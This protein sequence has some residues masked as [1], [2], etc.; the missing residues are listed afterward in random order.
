MAPT[1]TL[2]WRF[3]AVRVRLTFFR[4][5]G[6]C[7]GRFGWL[8]TLRLY[9]TGRFFTESGS[10]RSSCSRALDL[11]GAGGLDGTKP[12]SRRVAVPVVSAWPYCDR[13][14][15]VF[16]ARFEAKLSSNGL[17]LVLDQSGSGITL[18]EPMVGGPVSSFAA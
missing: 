3:H 4:C 6:L 7:Q 13:E 17:E 8:A 18:A 15:C 16:L 9:K 14:R 11:P 2:D 5:L 1:P 10:H 12:P